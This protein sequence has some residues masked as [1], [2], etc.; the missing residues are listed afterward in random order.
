MALK[1]QYHINRPKTRTITMENH[2]SFSFWRQ[3]GGDSLDLLNSTRYKH[4]YIYIHNILISFFRFP[5]LYTLFFCM[6]TR[7]KIIFKHAWRMTVYCRD[8][9]NCMNVCSYVHRKDMIWFDLVNGSVLWRR[10]NI[11]VGFKVPLRA[12]NPKHS[13]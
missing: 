11:S 2:C 12:L 10:K 4:M 5:S 13:V 8:T 3:T 9:S 6:N 1:P 7:L